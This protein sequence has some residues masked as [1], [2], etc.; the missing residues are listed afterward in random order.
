M[1]VAVGNVVR[2]VVAAGVVDGLKETVAGWGY[3]NHDCLR[4]SSARPFL[5]S[6]R[7]SGPRAV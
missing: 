7:I 3:S 1:Q 2:G 4:F 6:K 5:F